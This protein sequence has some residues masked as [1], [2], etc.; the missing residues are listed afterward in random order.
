MPSR[1]CPLC[2]VKLPHAAVLARSDDLVCPSCRAEL[3]LSRGSRVVAAFA[4]FLAACAA[5]YV[6]TH[7]LRNIA[8]VVAVAAAILVYGFCSALFL[9]LYSNL[10]VCPRPSSAFPHIHA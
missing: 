9:F 6:V 7:A 2:F 8:W 5:A 10:V 3:E 1:S 4:G